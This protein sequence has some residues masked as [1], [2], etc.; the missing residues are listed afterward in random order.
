MRPNTRDDFWAQVDRS[1]GSD[2]C[3]PWLGTR[4][5]DGRYG[6]FTQRG[7]AWLAHRYA[8]A[9]AIA[10]P[11][12]DLCVCH[13]CDTPVCCNPA[14]LFL[15]TNADNSA[16]MVSKGRTAPQKGEL[17]N[18]HILTEGWVRCI[19]ALRAEGLSYSAIA[20]EVPNAR[21]ANVGLICKRKGWVHL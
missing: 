18:G 14:H 5:A 3:W 19:R 1:A 17:N 11:E 6:R 8:Y 10:I 7:V 4:F 12:K 13:R 20:S 2:R 16:D 15:G 21:K 9:D